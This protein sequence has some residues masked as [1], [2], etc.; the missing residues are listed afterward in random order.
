MFETAKEAAE[1]ILEHQNDSINLISH[2]DADGISAAAI[3]SKT[4]DRMEIRHQVK[5][6]RMLYPEAIEELEIGEL[7]IFTDLGSSQLENLRPKLEGTESIIADHHSMGKR[8]EW[9]K[10][11]HFN[12]HLEGLDGVEEVSGSGM[13]YLVAK[14]LDSKNKDLSVQGLIGAIGD[15]QDA[16]GELKGFNRNIAQD[17]VEAGKIEQKEDLLFY[18][19]HTRP[20]FRALKN[21]TDPPIPGVSN[22]T[23]GCVSMLK[24]LGIPYKTEEGY[25]RPI[26]LTQDEKRKL[27][28][29]LI[30]RA[31][32]DVPEELVDYV[33]GL[34][35]GEVHTVVDEKERSLLKDADEFATC[36]NSTAR[37]EQP[38]IGLE[39]AKGNRDV[40][41]NQMLKL[42]RYHRRCIAEGMSYIE[43][44][45]IK[46]GPEDYL[47]YFD[48]SDVLRETFT[49]TVAGLTLGHEDADPYKPIMGFVKH[50]GVAKIS[51]RCSKLLFLKGLDMGD[52]I[53]NAAKAVG[54]DGGGHAVACGAQVDGNKISEFVNEFEGRL[55][56][57]V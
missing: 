7:N 17:A 31:I 27:A 1:V 19:R 21:F 48:A 8:D 3:M 16:W 44:K 22:S 57:E 11:T 51:A 32:S 28:T 40:Y 45:G 15:V 20:I 18:G 2:M 23:E 13:S 52:A 4:L 33:P 26:D 55:L 43:N 30:T 49:G 9:P 24:D 46:R 36:I 6:V 37:H 56:E 53:R 38:L 39:V 14:A 10:L 42:L 35:I 25:R 29:E 34:I 5:F 47:Q 41:Y 54:G 50:D 12:A